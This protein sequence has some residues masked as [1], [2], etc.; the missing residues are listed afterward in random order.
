[1]ENP[2]APAHDVLPVHFNN[3][4]HVLRMYD[5]FE[6]TFCRWSM[7]TQ[8]DRQ[9]LVVTLADGATLPH[10]V[11]CTIC[12]LYPNRVVGPF[13]SKNILIVEFL[14]ENTESEARVLTDTSSSCVKDKTIANRKR[15][16][17]ESESSLN[18]PFSQIGASVERSLNL[19]NN[20]SVFISKT[21]T[22]EDAGG[23]WISYT[24]SECERINLSFIPTVF[25]GPGSE[26]IKVRPVLCVL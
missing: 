19:A 5:K 22:G 20:S 6:N 1:M 7:V 4:L 24:I 3:I 10:S 16:F 2:I 14:N 23:L 9:Q 21:S 26:Q 13:L 11:M 12:L 25:A 15:L 18:D 8:K 17:S